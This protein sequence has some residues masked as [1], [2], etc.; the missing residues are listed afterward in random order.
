MAELE[1]INKT[2]LSMSEV[3]MRLETFKE[4]KEL[5]YRSNKVL[6]HIQQFPTIKQEAI[7]A[8]TE[9]LASLGITRLKEKQITKLIDTLPTT[10]EQVKATLAGENITVKADDLKRIAEA[11]IKTQ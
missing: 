1:I 10:E 8:V 9:E 3:K 11:I 4:K 5:N 7:K 6:D 2:A